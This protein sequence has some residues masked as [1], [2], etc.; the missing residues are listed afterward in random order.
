MHLFVCADNGV[1]RARLNAK[2]AT[3]AIGL[4]NNHRL[5]GLKSTTLGVQGLYSQ[6]SQSG[7]QRNAGI[8]AGWAAIDRFVFGGDRFG[9]VPA[10]WVAAAGALRL[11]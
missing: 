5:L 7:Q 6:F 1:D 11:R 8:T 9:V 3:D 4:I 10:A 2:K